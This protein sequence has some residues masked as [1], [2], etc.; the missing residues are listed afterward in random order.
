[1]DVYEYKFSDVK[2]TS[3]TNFQNTIFGSV[4]HAVMQ[5]VKTERVWKGLKQKAS[6]QALGQLYKTFLSEIPDIETVLLSY[7]RY[8]L[9]CN[10]VIEYDYSH[11]DV[12]KVSQTAKIVHREKTPDGSV[13]EVSG[14]QRRIVL[15][16]C[17][18]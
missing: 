3:E 8:V 17:Q 10:K 1:M 12:L 4:H 9:S 7:I 16:R 18:S 11:P 13:R 2:F 5:Q 6:T 14:N 15:C